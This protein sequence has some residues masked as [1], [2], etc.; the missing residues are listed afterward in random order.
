MKEGIEMNKNIILTELLRKLPE[1][2][3]VFYELKDDKLRV[4]IKDNG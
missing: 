1:M 2:E 3:D 4:Y